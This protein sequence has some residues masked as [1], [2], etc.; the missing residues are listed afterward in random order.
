MSYTHVIILSFPLWS[1]TSLLFLLQLFWCHLLCL[2]H[3]LL[4]LSSPSMLISLGSHSSLISDQLLPAHHFPHGSSY[5]V[6]ISV[7]PQIWPS[8]QKG[9]HTS[10][11]LVTLGSFLTIP[12]L[13]MLLWGLNN[14]L[15]MNCLE[16][17]LAY[18]K[19]IQM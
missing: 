15:L 6:Y 4:C 12:T 18:S 5:H 16:E 13:T 8:Y 1:I 7:T 19:G 14:S 3:G 17:C 11:P 9:C 2:Q 10:I